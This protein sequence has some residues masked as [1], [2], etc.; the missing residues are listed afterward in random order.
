MNMAAIVAGGNVRVGLEDNIYYDAS[1]SLLA[2]NTMLVERVV[3]IS[4][5]LGREIATPE[6]TRKLLEIF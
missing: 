4:H 3:R 5:E 2:T 6:Y 1:K